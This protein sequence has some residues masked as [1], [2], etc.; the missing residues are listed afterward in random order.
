MYLVLASFSLAHLRNVSFF[1]P[2]ALPWWFLHKRIKLLYL[3]FDLSPPIWWK[4]KSSVHRHLSGSKRSHT[5]RARFSIL[6]D[7]SLGIC[8]LILLACSSPDSDKFL[9]AVLNTDQA[10]CLKA[11]YLI[12]AKPMPATTNAVPNPHQIGFPSHQAE[13]NPRRTTLA[14]DGKTQRPRCL[15]LFLA[16]FFLQVFL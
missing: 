3:E 11:G 1:H 5:P 15:L 16:T 7:T 14:T 4:S 6:R 12:S 8:A 2:F 13:I 9:P 10:I